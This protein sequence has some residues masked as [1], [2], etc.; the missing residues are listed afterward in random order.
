[1]PAYENEEQEKA[2]ESLN[3]TVDR[4]QDG[5]ATVNK[6]IRIPIVGNSTFERMLVCSVEFILLEWGFDIQ[7]SGHSYN[8]REERSPKTDS[9][10][11]LQ[12]PLPV[13]IY[14]RPVIAEN[15]SVY[16]NLVW[17]YILKILLSL[18]SF[19][20]QWYCKVKYVT[21]LSPLFWKSLHAQGQSGTSKLGESFVL[22]SP[23][24]LHES[25]LEGVAF[26][27]YCNQ[28]Y[29][30]F[31]IIDDYRDTFKTLLHYVYY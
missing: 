3:S 25:K 11:D 22:K 8:S 16:F 23:L 6:K 19:H 13:P 7:L 14:E 27:P 31:S 28:K 21:R 5:T 29:S 17:Y 12:P 9:K 30:L 2:K 10:T 15:I 1:M 20:N 18:Q 26:L 4:R 24:R